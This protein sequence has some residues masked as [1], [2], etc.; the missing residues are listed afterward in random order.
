ML[1]LSKQ[2]Q[3]AIEHIP[4][5]H[6]EATTEKHST[7][8]GHAVHA[9]STKE[10]RMAYQKLRLLYPESDHIMLA[11]NVKGHTGHHDHREYGAS[12]KMLQILSNRGMNNTAVFITREYGGIQ[13]GLRCFLFIEGAARDALNK[14]ENQQY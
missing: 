1:S 14:L 11:Y 12:R 6:A 5:V 10:V 9:K 8:R 2:E 13:L 3:E 4:M 7:F